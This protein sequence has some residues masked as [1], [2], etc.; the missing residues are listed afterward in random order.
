[1]HPF[2]PEV[3]FLTRVGEGPRGE[4]RQSL[5]VSPASSICPLAFMFEVREGA[6]CPGD[7]ALGSSG[8][9]TSTCQSLGL[10][11]AWPVGS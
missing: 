6:G 10:Q 4:R 11:A 2:A 3:C 5:T 7:L 9:E 8:R 1:M